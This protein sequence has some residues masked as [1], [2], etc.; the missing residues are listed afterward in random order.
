MVMN[1]EYLKKLYKETT[2]YKERDFDWSEMKK[3]KNYVWVPQGSRLGN[4]LITFDDDYEGS[5][6]DALF[7]SELLKAFDKEIRGE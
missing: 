2:L 1:I 7:I 3:E 5:G 4:T 6:E